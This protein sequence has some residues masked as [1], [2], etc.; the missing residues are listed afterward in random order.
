MEQWL[1][2]VTG[3]NVEVDTGV[4]SRELAGF[5]QAKNVCSP[6]QAVPQLEN[7]VFACAVSVLKS[8]SG[9]LGGDLLCSAA[10]CNCL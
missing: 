3:A 1:I 10:L 6:R 5:V 2:L 8:V 4:S 7:L 9:R